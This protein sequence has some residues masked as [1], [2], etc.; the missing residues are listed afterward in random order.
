MKRFANYIPLLGL[1]LL[2]VPAC[3][4]TLDEVKPNKADLDFS[5]YIAYGDYI[6]AG[7][8]NG[9]VTRESQQYA[10]P[11]ILAQQFAKA[12]GPQTFE[13]PYFDALEGQQEITVTGYAADGS[14]ILS[15]SDALLKTMLPNC[16]S[17]PL[18]VFAKYSGNLQNL[19]NLGV[20]GLRIRQL[21]K[22]GVGNVANNS[23]PFGNP[24]KF[25]PYLE[26]LL[27]ASDSR[28][29]NDVA[30]T[31]K[32]TFFTCWFGMSDV[33]AYANSGVN[34]GSSCGALS[35]PTA[36]QFN[37]EV[38]A[39]LDSVSA[40][41]TIKGVVCNIPNFEDLAISKAVN[42]LKVQQQYHDMYPVSDSVAIW[43]TSNTGV[44]K[45]AS[46]DYLLPKALP[47]LNRKDPALDTKNVNGVDQIEPYG[48]SKYN[49]LPTEDV[50]DAFEA[51]ILN[52]R[53]NK[54]FNKALN[55]NITEVAGKYHNVLAVADMNGLFFSMRNGVIFSGVK[56]NANLVTGGFFSLDNFSVTPRG[57]AI[58]ANKIIQTMN[59]AFGSNIGEVNVNDFPTLKLP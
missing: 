9:A 19:Q 34:G 12:G 59:N 58:I 24:P 22:A 30:K 41:G 54:N 51:G 1:F 50:L 40:K 13:Q 31:A 33:I 57:Q 35:L 16:E 49:P 53:I 44:R 28:S 2:A 10:Y 52:E 20:P 5:H 26:R 14:P 8:M 47:K 37:T 36:T 25:N 7:Y 38:L 3:K 21:N 15:A 42:T 55:D 48:L 11:A 18:P 27:P 17:A 32:P 4:P 46:N 43:I 6:T 39:F 56:Y 23:T 29:Y 45:I